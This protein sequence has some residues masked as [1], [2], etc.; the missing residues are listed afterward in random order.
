C[1]A[2][3]WS[4]GRSVG[5]RRRAA[6]G[7]HAAGWRSGLHL[8]TGTRH[9]GQ[10]GDDERARPGV[11]LRSPGPLPRPAP[12]RRSLSMSR[13]IIAVTDTA[14]PDDSLHPQLAEQDEAAYR[15]WDGDADVAA[16]LD[17]DQLRFTICV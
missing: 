14:V 9:S 10:P 16:T 1:G 17:G 5:G 6:P 2:F 15:Q 7:L 13:P 8:C 4:T 12:V 11:G 3:L